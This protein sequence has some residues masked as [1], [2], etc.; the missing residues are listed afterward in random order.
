MKVVGKTEDGYICEVNHSEI[1]KF[2]NLYYGKLQRINIGAIIDL[3]KGY[4]FYQDTKKCLEITQNFINSNKNIIESILNG[5]Q[6]MGHR[7]ED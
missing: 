6:I 4:D 2:L 3:G 1:E 5:I 7:K